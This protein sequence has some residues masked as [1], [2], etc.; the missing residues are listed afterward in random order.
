MVVAL[1][2]LQALKDGWST[3]SLLV[4]SFDYEELKIFQQ[5][6][7][8][9]PLGL[10]AYGYPL[11]CIE[12]AKEFGVYSVHLHIDSVSERR[13]R[14]L[15]E[16]GFKVFVYT[17]NEPSDIVKMKSFGVDGIFSDFPERILGCA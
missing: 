14:A 9:I 4:S 3:Q 16:A 5:T 11:K 13:V 8:S 1:D 10:L 12:L 2:L 17:V 6:A 15:R 7:P